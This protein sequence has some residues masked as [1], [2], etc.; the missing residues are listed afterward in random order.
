M[1]A[2]KLARGAVLITSLVFYAFLLVIWVTS[3]AHPQLTADHIQDDNGYGPRA[4]GFQERAPRSIEDTKSDGMKTIDSLSANSNDNN[5]VDSLPSN[6]N[7][8]D[9]YKTIDTSLSDIF[10]SVKTTKKFHST[11]LDIIL[12]TWFNLA[13]EQV[14]ISQSTLESFANN[15]SSDY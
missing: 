3:N 6:D 15:R 2:T 8:R 4:Y 9:R 12:K 14:F 7:Q 10:I 1:R 13:K 11:R 5:L